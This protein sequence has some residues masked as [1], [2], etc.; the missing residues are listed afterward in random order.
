[1]LALT[2]TCANTEDVEVNKVIEVVLFWNLSFSERNSPWVII[3]R[4]S[5]LQR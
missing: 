4:I 1:M 2:W 3:F 5:G